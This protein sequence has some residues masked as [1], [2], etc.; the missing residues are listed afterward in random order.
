[1]P[2]IIREN[3][4]RDY[5]DY[6][7]D[8]SRKAGAADS[9][10]F[11]ESEDDVRE[12]LRR[13]KS[14]G[15]PTTFQGART[16]IVAGAAPGG[17]HA[18]NLS[19]MARVLGMRHEAK[20]QAF[21]LT[22]QPGVALAEARER[23]ARRDFD[24]QGWSADSLAAL[25]AFRKAEPH[26]FAPDP[27]ET[28]ATIGGMAACNSSGARSFRFGPMARHVEALRVVFADGDAVSLRRGVQCAEGRRFRLE[29]ESGAAIE[30]FLPGYASP[31]VKNAAGYCVADDMDLLDLF[32]GSEGTLGAI[33]E[34]EIRLLP[35]PKAMWALMA[36]MP[37]EA[38][39]LKLTRL[40]R[41]EAV[42]GLACRPSVR[43]AAIELFNHDALN[44]L[45][46][47]KA[48]NPA[49]GHLP[50][51]APDWR[52]AVYFEFHA[53]SAGE[54]ESAVMQLAEAMAEL[55]GSDEAAWL[56]SDERELERLKDFRHAVP[57]AVNLLI[58]RRRQKHPGLTKLGTDMAF[59]DSELENAM[60]MYNEGLAEAGLES[61]IFGHVGDNHLHVNILPRDQKDYDRGKALYLSWAQEAVRRGGSVSAEHGIGK[62]K[63]AFLKLMY[64]EEGIEQMRALKRLFDPEMLLNRGN[65]FEDERERAR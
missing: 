38:E 18:M 28:S 55:G 21:F 46:E 8:E 54:A 52:T 61:V 12:T 44:L 17:G 5:A 40:A 24:T 29:L 4:E 16:G 22:V 27:T 37:G 19:R 7:H 62:L 42:E 35:A 39:A 43:P 11:P 57:E 34:I 51:I 26:F 49:F 58:G 6:L 63:T 23:I 14:E 45:R 56:A 41:G 65:L 15:E 50:E 30:G 60:K 1:M 20:P 36:F 47:Q 9:I 48:T 59:P 13:M 33:V 25:E 2:K 32:L 3:I 64:G 53:D 31:H 10:S